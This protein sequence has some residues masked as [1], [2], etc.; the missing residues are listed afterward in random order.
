MM[1]REPLAQAVGQL[2]RRRVAQADALQRG[3]EVHPLD[4]QVGLEGADGAVVVAVGV[5]G[6]RVLFEGPD[7]DGEDAEGD[8]Y[9][10]RHGLFGAVVRGLL[11]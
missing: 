1:R 10:F 3:L 8:A 11:R 7:D 9:G 4:L 5:E 2:A 6:L